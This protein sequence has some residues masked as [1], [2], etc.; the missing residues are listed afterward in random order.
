MEILLIVL[1]AGAVFF[2]VRSLLRRRSEPAVSIA[3][4]S[5]VEIWARAEV[6]RMLAEKLELEESDVSETLGG[7]PDP[8]LV[9]RIEKTVSGVEVVYS[10]AL[11]AAGNADVRVDIRLEK[12][13]MLRSEKRIPWGELPD[14]VKDDFAKTGTAHVYRPWQ[15]PW[16][17]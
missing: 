16:Q 15:F 9:T 6:A 3:K 1:L 2:A 11:G 5:A 12:G 10:R 13:D 14:H 7:S 17:S 8:D 4:D